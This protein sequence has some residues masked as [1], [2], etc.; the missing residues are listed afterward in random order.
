MA[1]WVVAVQQRQERA[2]GDRRRKVPELP[3]AI[4]P[5]SLHTSEI[6]LAKTRAEKRGSHERCS[7]LGKPRQR[8]Q[9]KDRRVGADVHVVLS[10][11]RRQCFRHFNR[12]ERAGALVRHV[13]GN[14]GKTQATWR[15]G[16][17][18]SCDLHHERHDRDGVVLDGSH[19]ETVAQGVPDDAREI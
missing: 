1:V 12:A 2:L 8:R 9:S 7:P 5:E 19:V 17:Q 14:R 10:P 18:P 4:E 6:R 13:G 16:P 3:Q 15:I 11:D